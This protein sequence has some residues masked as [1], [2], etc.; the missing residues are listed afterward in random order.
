M[1]IVV[2][3]SLTSIMNHLQWLAR[4]INQDYVGETGGWSL[5]QNEHREVSDFTKLLRTKYAVLNN[6]TDWWCVIS[7]NG[8]GLFRNTMM[9][10]MIIMQMMTSYM[11]FFLWCCNNITRKKFFLRQHI[12][13]VLFFQN[14]PIYIT[15]F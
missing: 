5:D 12:V 3:V 10:M 2:L 4:R 1:I 9:M 13:G 11:F 7:L 15:I 6:T 8:V 14:Q